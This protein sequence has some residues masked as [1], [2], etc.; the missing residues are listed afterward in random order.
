MLDKVIGRMREAG[1]NGMPGA[2]T[3]RSLGAY[4]TKLELRAE[5]SS[6]LRSQASQAR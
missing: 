4:A 6:S 2:V 5:G 1:A 3:S